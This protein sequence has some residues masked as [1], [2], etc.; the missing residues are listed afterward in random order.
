M[1]ITKSEKC[2]FGF[3][4]PTSVVKQNSFKKNN[5]TLMLATCYSSIENY[6]KIDLTLTILF[7]VYFLYQNTFWVTDK[8]LPIAGQK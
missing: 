2:L 7:Y 5:D 1:E 4:H 3:N 8:E 6:F